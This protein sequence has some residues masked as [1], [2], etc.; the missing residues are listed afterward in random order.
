MAALAAAASRTRLAAAAGVRR[1][2][3]D[4]HRTGP[5]QARCLLWR[6]VLGQRPEVVAPAVSSSLPRERGSQQRQTVQMSD[7]RVLK[8]KAVR[9]KGSWEH[10]QIIALGWGAP[11]LIIRCNHDFG[12]ALGS[13]IK[14]HVGKGR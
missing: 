11:A 3:T 14:P 6:Q 4:A 1:R 2:L 13:V 10:T 5:L 7:W 12:A 9:M 8:R